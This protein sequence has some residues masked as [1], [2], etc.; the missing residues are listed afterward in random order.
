MCLLALPLHFVYIT[1]QI[2]AILT[3]RKIP[4]VKMK[5]RV[6]FSPA[7]GYHGKLLGAFQEMARRYTQQ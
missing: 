6:P 3:N 7:F 1:R 2:D 4:G 5:T